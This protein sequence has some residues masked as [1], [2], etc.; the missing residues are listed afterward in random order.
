M[1]QKAGHMSGSERAYSTAPLESLQ[2]RPDDHCPGWQRE[3]VQS[4]DGATAPE[5]VGAR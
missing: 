3:G 5:G 4:S 2:V 1:E